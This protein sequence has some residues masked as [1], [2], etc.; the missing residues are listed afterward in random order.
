MNVL[1]PLAPAGIDPT[2]LIA[3]NAVVAAGAVIGLPLLMAVLARVVRRSRVTIATFGLLLTATIALQVWLGVLLMFDQPRVPEG[4]G[5][6]Y[7]LQEGPGAQ[8]AS[9]VVDSD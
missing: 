5:D 1:A 8:G 6:W 4:A 7:R 3:P 9:P 2:A